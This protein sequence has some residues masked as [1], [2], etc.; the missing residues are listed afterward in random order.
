MT[1]EP[2][3]GFTHQSFLPIHKDGIKFILLF[4]LIS[5]GLYFIYPPFFF[6]GLVLTAWCFYFFRTPKRV[7]PLKP[8]LII[9]PADGIV[10]L[11]KEVEP[12][13]DY[14]IG[15]QKRWRV[16]IFLNV[17]DVHIQRI[18]F[19]GTISTIIYHPGKFFNASL[20]KASEHNERQTIVIQG[21]YKDQEIK[22]ACTQIAGLIARRIL[23]QIQE[24]QEVSIGELYGLIRFGSRVDIYL[25]VGLQPLVLA[26]QRMIGGET[27]IADCAQL[28]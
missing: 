16:S 26:G 13:L 20:D 25:P 17:F 24:G 1:T 14:G 27:I 6:I 12:P 23:C 5:C 8:G 22:M 7:T 4:A 9:S 28:S 2:P 18:P 11:I 10:S 3:A 19:P 15:S 21:K